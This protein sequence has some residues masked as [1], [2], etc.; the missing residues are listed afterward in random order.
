MGR[1]KP[2]SDHRQLAVA[3]STQRT[4]QSVRL[5]FDSARTTDDNYRHWANADGFSADATATGE[6][7][8]TLRNRCRYEVANNAYARGMVLTLAHDVVGTG[9]RLQL[10]TRDAEYNR[11]AEVDGLEFTYVVVEAPVTVSDYSTN[12]GEYNIAV[13]KEVF[14]RS[15]AFAGS[16]YITAIEYK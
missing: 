14:V 11:R 5:G 2:R 12:I 6:I 3:Q 16:G 15:K 7:R 1:K 9:P 8:R 4:A 13:N 10:L